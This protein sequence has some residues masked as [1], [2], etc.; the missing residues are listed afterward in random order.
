MSKRV[1][2]G[3]EIAVGDMSEAEATVVATNRTGHRH[4]H[5]RVRGRSGRSGGQTWTAG[6]SQDRK[7]SAAAGLTEWIGPPPQSRHR[8]TECDLFWRSLSQALAGRFA[9]HHI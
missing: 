4:R 1:R 9:P 3:R 2:L 6:L 7:P 8:Q 5:V